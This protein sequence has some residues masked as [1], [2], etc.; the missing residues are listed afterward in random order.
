MFTRGPSKHFSGPAPSPPTRPKGPCRPLSTH[1]HIRLRLRRIGRRRF[2]VRHGH[3]HRRSKW[4]FSR[5]RCRRGRRRRA[6][7]GRDRHRRRLAQLACRLLHWKTKRRDERQCR[8]NK[9]GGKRLRRIA[10]GLK[11]FARWWRTH[12]VALRSSS[13]RLFLRRRLWRSIAYFAVMLAVAKGT[14]ARRTL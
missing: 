6:R 14:V 5:R 2:R 7:R 12:V 8:R 13:V 1:L 10:L 3:R 9:P 4:K 11:A